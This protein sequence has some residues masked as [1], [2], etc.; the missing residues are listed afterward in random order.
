[1]FNRLGGAI[2]R[3]V[4]AT[5]HNDLSRRG[6]A[7]LRRVAPWAWNGLEPFLAR[8]PQ[9]AKT[10][11]A[12]QTETGHARLLIDVSTTARMPAT[13]S[14]IQ[15][16]VR[17]LSRALN[18]E[19]ANYPLGPLPVRIEHVRGAMWEL[20]AT[21]GFPDDITTRGP[22][23][24]RPGDILL[25]LD[26]TW[27]FYGA[28]ARSVFPVVKKQGG[29]IITCVYDI[30]PVTH[31]QFFR[32]RDVAIFNS[33][34]HDALKESDA[35]LTISNA[36]RAEV[37]RYSNGALPIDFFHL[38]ADFMQMPQLDK[39]RNGFIAD[40]GPLFLM[41][42]TIEP[43]KGH[44]VALDAFEMLWRKGSQA[45][46]AIVGSEGWNVAPL[47]R[48]IRRLAKYEP[49]FSFFPRV[50][51][52]ALWLLYEQ[53]TAIIAASLAEGFGLPVIE[54]MMRGKPVVA[55]DIPAFLEVGAGHPI[56]FPVGNAEALAAAV[57]VLARGPIA[58]TRPSSKD[59]L[60]WNQSADM[61]MDRIFSLSQLGPPRL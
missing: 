32:K 39:P 4:A 24:I 2:H 40:E 53:A 18:R 45:R 11:R 38:G 57:E 17:S 36:T 44:A 25:M 43:R 12:P 19:A 13:L 48:R 28:F 37:D 31:P 35:L 8:L 59:W 60:S 23:A 51:D 56:F 61:L 42:G 9:L 15:R 29:R 34:F 50:S 1:M 6:E 54:A 14:G 41:V 49:R 30:L 21:P 52:G 58:T 33:W 47:L 3:A 5:L 22:I 26:S 7:G 16:T 10:I 46:L 27:I 20:R 55:S